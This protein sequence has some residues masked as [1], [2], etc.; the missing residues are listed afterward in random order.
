MEDLRVDN[1]KLMYHI[2]RLHSWLR[3][4]DIYPVYIEISPSGTCNHR[5]I[6]CAFEYLNYKSQFID[7]KVLKR[8]LRGLAKCRVKSIMFSGEGEP[9]LHKNLPEFILYAKQVGLDVAC[10]INGVLFTPEI[11]KQCLSALTWIKVS[12]NAG[13]RK[14]YSKIH[15]CKEKDFDKVIFNLKEAVDIKRQNGH[16]CTIG[17]QIV[18]LPENIKEIEILANSLRKIGIQYL[19]VKPFIKHLMSGHNI[20][21]EITD[22]E[23]FALENRLKEF[24]KNDFKIYF[25]A[26]SF[27]KLKEPRPYKRCLGLPFF[28]EIT[29]NGNIYTCGPYLGDSNFCYGNIYKDSFIEI[30]KG[31]KR[32]QILERISKLDVSRCMKNCRLDEINRYLWELRNL[33][34]HVNFI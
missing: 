25:R 26:H 19:V 7:K 14:T 15:G 30:W 20:S 33:P 13:T 17:A 31:R 2:E 11:A 4:E 16:P 9:F 24:S 1:H 27:I 28:C 6:F 32:K 21:R 34:P 29:S 5:C 18:L 8:T 10:A 22:K 3:G 23:L 12:I